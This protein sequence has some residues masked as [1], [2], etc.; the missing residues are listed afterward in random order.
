MYA[1]STTIHGDPQAMEEGIAF[2]RD[3]V[4]PAVERME[5]CVG[6]SMLADRERGTCI[7]STAWRDQD[8]MHGSREG[9]RSIRERAA[10]VFG[11]SPEVQ[12][13]EIAVMHRVHDTRAGACTRVTWTRADPDQMDRAVDAFRMS[14]VPR[15]E[16]YPGF[17]SV[18]LMVSRPEGMGVSAV[19]FADRAA[20]ENTRERARAMRDE[21]APQLGM[22]ITDIAEF[23]LVLAHLRVPETA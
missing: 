2:V 1:R 14:L 16:E 20:M 3:E 10:E 15:M 8:S 12:E 18:S 6:L 4:M 17:C 11:G 5:G 22:A 13:W 9:V 19:T 7:V 23:E 21:F